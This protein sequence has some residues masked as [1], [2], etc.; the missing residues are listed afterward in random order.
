MNKFLNE[1]ESLLRDNDVSE[2]DINEV[3]SDY[4]EFYEEYQSKG[5]NEVEISR[6]LGTPN[7]IYLNVLET[8]KKKEIERGYQKKLVSVS[9]FI[10]T[11]IFFVVGYI[12]DVWHPTWL[13]FLIIPLSGVLFNGK[14]FGDKAVAASVFL[15]V[16]GYILIGHYIHIWHPTWLV[17]FLI[18]VLGILNGREGI[19]NK[20]L[21]ASVFVSTILA[22]VLTHYHILSWKFAWLLFLTVAVLG[23]LPFKKPRDYKRI[24][25]GISLILAIIF[26]IVLL[27]YNVRIPLALLVFLLPLVVAIWSSHININVQVD[28]RPKTIILSIISLAVIIGFIYF[29]ITFNNWAYIWQVLLIIP[30]AAIILSVDEKFSWTAIMPFIAVV[31]FFS[32]GYFYNAWGISW[33]AF[34]LIPIVGVLE[35]KNS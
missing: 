4:E 32:L 34:L 2:K 33:L 24:I 7:D 13:V 28:K 1:L 15:S 18:P 23:S 9:P 17:F 31:L 20:L 14:S 30:V 8:L 5:M 27:I 10:A 25:L 21:G 26:Y 29:G 19:Y 35:D 22:L 16:G 12:T 3:V 6:R 11:I